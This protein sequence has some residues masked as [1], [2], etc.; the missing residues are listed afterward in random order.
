VKGVSFED[1]VLSGCPADGGMFMPEAIPSLSKEQLKQWSTLN[2]P[3][4]VEKLLR[5][6]VDQDEMTDEDIRG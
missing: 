1:A 2:Y 5:L 4:L 3:R 6:F